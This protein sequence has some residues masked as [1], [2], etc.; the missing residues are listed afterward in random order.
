MEQE[1][2]N[3]Q[4]LMESFYSE[5]VGFSF[6]TQLVPATRL[7]L[8]EQKKLGFVMKGADSNSPGKM[9]GT[10]ST[11]GDYVSKRLL[12][13]Y[14]DENKKPQFL[15]LLSAKFFDITHFLRSSNP[16]VVTHTDILTKEKPHPNVLSFDHFKESTSEEHRRN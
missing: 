15:H 9:I 14:F 16:K 5:K 13:C 12:C 6:Q 4:S 7:N 10:L 11:I 1:A 8:Y 3:L 2:R